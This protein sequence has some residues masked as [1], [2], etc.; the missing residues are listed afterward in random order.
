MSPA[1]LPQSEG[2]P[3]NA[4]T[5]ADVLHLLLLVEQD[6]VCLDLSEERGAVTRSEF[7][8]RRGVLDRL[9]S[10]LSAELSA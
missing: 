6:K 4:L 8:K 1:A 9:H 3:I 10:I 2:S 5:S 7:T